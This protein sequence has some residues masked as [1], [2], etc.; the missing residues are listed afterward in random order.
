MDGS[1]GSGL[2]QLRSEAA[3]APAEDTTDQPLHGLQDSCRFVTVM[4]PAVRRVTLLCFDRLSCFHVCRCECVCVCAHVC[5][6]ERERE[7]TAFHF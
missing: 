6:C 5:V 3:E 1:P 4:G 2:E 7:D